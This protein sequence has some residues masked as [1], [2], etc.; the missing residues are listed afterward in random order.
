MARDW[1]D[2][3]IEELERENAVLRARIVQLEARLRELEALLARYSGNSSRW[4]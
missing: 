2:D 3:R 1:R 4:C